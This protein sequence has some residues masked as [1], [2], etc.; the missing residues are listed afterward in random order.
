MGE[1]Y[2]LLGHF[3]YLDLNEVEYDGHVIEFNVGD[4]AMTTGFVVLVTNLMP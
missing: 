4:V 1:G 2:F 3:V